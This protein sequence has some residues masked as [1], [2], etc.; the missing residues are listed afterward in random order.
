MSMRKAEALRDLP[1]W[2]PS[3]LVDL[4]MVW[5]GSFFRMQGN[6]T[7]KRHQIWLVSRM[8]LEDLPL[9]LSLDYAPGYHPGG[10]EFDKVMVPMIRWRL[11]HMAQ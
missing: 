2:V 4:K 3:M 7:V 10:W 9:F 1:A 8:P 5:K 6:W 11:T